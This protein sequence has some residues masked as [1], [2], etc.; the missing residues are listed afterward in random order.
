MITPNDGYGDYRVRDTR[1]MEGGSPGNVN[2][3]RTSVVYA[4]EGIKAFEW[5]DLAILHN[6]ATQGENCADYRQAHAYS[7]GATWGRCTELQDHSGQGALIGHEYGMVALGP[8]NGSRVFNDMVLM[9]E[10][11]YGIRA[12]GKVDG[13]SFTVGALFTHI[14][15]TGL[16]LVSRLAGA[17]RGLHL[18]GKYV[19]GIDFA[20]S[21]CDV[22]VRLKPGQRITLDQNSY[23]SVKWE[24][25]RLKVLAGVVP[26]FEIDTNNG[27]I[28]KM[29]VKVL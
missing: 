15:D 16:R 5:A 4:G 13:D 26:V 23:T 12:R 20:D 17:V 14:K 22:A 18:V 10:A 11:T 21:D 7:T 3:V 29:G 8:D 25:G 28:Y 1:G 27:D 6:Y 9:G 2:T 19:I 24:N